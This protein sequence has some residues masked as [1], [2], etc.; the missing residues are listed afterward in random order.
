MFVHIG[1]SAVCCHET[2]QEKGVNVTSRKRP[3]DRKYLHTGAPLK[4]RMQVISRV[5]CLRQHDLHH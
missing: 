2:A 1:I 5:C 3:T 4:M